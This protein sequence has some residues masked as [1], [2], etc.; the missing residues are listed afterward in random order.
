MLSQVINQVQHQALVVQQHNMMNN[1]N[2]PSGLS[3]NPLVQQHHMMSHTNLPPG[4]PANPLVQQHHMMSHTN[5]PPG[6]PANPL[7]SGLP[8]FNQPVRASA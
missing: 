2:L 7:I 8:L 6:L 1:P 3:A 5:L 4:L